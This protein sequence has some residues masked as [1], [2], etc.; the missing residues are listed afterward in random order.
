[1]YGESKMETYNELSIVA[2]EI[3]DI[4]ENRLKA[5]EEARMAN[6]VI[7]QKLKEASNRLKNMDAKIK[8]LQLTRSANFVTSLED[9]KVFHPTSGK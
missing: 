4:T 5:E 2:N 3:F 1:M 6:N 9:T 7:I 8:A